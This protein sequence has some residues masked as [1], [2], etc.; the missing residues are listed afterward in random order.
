MT[1][2]LLAYA[3]ANPGKVAAWAASVLALFGV[4]LSPEV[5]G[6]A[7]QALAVLLGG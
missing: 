4:S 5:Q 1:A 2:R 7:L 3:K 6:L